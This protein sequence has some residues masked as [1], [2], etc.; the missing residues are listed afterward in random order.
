[1]PDFGE[2]GVFLSFSQNFLPLDRLHC[3]FY[4]FR[5]SS[6]YGRIVETKSGGTPS[7][8]NGWGSLSGFAGQPPHRGETWREPSEAKRTTRHGHFIGVMLYHQVLC[9]KYLSISYAIVIARS[10]VTVSV[11]VIIARVNMNGII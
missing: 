3:C 1:M 7:R 4:G 6:R 10:G 8:G 2:N 9:S 5:T 11:E